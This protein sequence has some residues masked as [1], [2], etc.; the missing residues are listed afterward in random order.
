[1]LAIQNIAL[2]GI[3]VFFS[4]SAKPVV[5]RLSIIDLSATAVTLPAMILSATNP[6]MTTRTGVTGGRAVAVQV[7]LSANS[8]II[9]FILVS[10]PMGLVHC[11][12]G[13]ALD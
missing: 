1:M 8:R 2:G 4:K 7:R 9:F 5:S 10:H 6:F 11:G 12:L 3:V 13:H